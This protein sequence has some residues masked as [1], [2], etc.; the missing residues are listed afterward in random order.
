M[1]TWNELLVALVLIGSE[2]WQTV[3]LG[4]LQF[5]GQFASRY[6]VVMAAIVIAIAPVLTIYVFLQKY[7]S[8]EMSSGALK[9]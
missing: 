9:E 4:L 1:G 6:T 8:T 5:Q 3:P 7:L 2:R